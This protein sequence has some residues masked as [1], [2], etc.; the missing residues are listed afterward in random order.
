M[1]TPQDHFEA[2]A[3]QLPIGRD[4]LSVRRR[5]EAMEAVLERIFVIP[6]INRPVGLDSIIGLVPVVGDVVTAAM[7]AWLVWEARNLG[8][9]KF[10]LWRMMGNIGVDTAIGAI[11]LVGD[12]FD[13]AFRSNTRNLKIL[14]RWLDKHHPATVVVEGEVV[15]RDRDR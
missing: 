4:P 15:A 11:P 1:P 12:L 5:L 10:Q 6:G 7:G 2:L 9:S 13:F 3:D 14:K 8:M